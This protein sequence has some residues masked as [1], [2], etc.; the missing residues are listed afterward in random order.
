MK[1]VEPINLAA[2]DL[3]GEDARKIKYKKVHAYGKKEYLIE[4]S[5]T[6]NKYFIISMRLNRGRKT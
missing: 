1:K 3:G 6:K 4:I 5:K 2:V